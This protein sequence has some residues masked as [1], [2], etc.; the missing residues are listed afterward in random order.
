[1]KF[2][3]VITLIILI[4][5]V[6][7]VSIIVN[8]L[9]AKET[10]NKFHKQYN[11][12]QFDSIWSESYSA[13]KDST[14]QSDFINYMQSVQEKLGKVKS[15]IK[16]GIGQFK[17]Y[18]W[19]Q[20]GEMIQVSEFEKG[21]DT[22]T[23]IFKFFKGNALITDYRFQ[24]MG[25]I[26]RQS[27]GTNLPKQPRQKVTSEHLVKYISGLIFI[28][29]ALSWIWGKLFMQCPVCG[30]Y[31]S[32]IWY[33]YEPDIHYIEKGMPWIERYLHLSC[34]K[35]NKEYHITTWTRMQDGTIHRVDEYK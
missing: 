22:E 11:N 29:L 1:M 24:S 14:S 8:G 18:K 30:K 10:I 12:S 17:K 26:K 2:K 35:C 9:V 21:E 19:I 16:P 25:E 15:S 33:T 27:V 13:F 34:W 7:T 32:R 6:W 23:F 5:L 4:L 28:L 31:T 3:F 20:E